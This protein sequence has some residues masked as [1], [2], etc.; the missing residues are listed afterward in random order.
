MSRYLRFF[1][2]LL[3]S[4]ALPL[5]GM[6]GVPSSTEPCPMQLSDMAM[7]SD[8]AP[9]CCQEGAT[10]ADHGKA[11]KP[12]QECK[13]GGVLQL[14]IPLLKAPMIVSSPLVVSLSSDFTPDRTP[15]GV[16][17]PPRS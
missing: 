10:P 2:V 9:D 5:T 3:L 14:S 15:S 1:L 7:M 6:A 8:M 17:R 11:C 16:W 13:T 4:L 12:G